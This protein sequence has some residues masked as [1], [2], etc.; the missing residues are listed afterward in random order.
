MS[1]TNPNTGISYGYISANA[2]DS[3][4]VHTLMHEVGD[5]LTMDEAEL[6]YAITE[7]NYDP[8]GKITLEDFLADHDDELEDF[9]NE[10]QCDEP[11]VM[12][13]YEEIKYLSSWLGGALNF[14]IT[15]S[16]YVTKEAQECSPCVPGA[17]NL[18][19]LD[20][21]YECYTVLAYWRCET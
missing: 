4:L 3:D 21:E 2:L 19:T 8:K 16:P 6:E 1:N 12:G 13:E 10:Y 14:F 15:E 18:D 5:D 9:R 17:G 20:G 11:I 7:L